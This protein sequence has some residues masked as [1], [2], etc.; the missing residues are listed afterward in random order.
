MAD[1]YQPFVMEL[2]R[3]MEACGQHEKEVPETILLAVG[4]VPNAAGRSWIELLTRIY[5]NKGRNVCNAKAD[6]EANLLKMI[7][8]KNKK[9]SASAAPEPAKVLRGASSSA[10]PSRVVVSPSAEPSRVV[11]LPT[12]NRGLQM[13]QNMQR[14][15]WQMSRQLQKTDKQLQKTDKRQEEMIRTLQDGVRIKRAEAVRAYREEHEFELREEA[16][17]AIREEL[18]TEMAR[19][20]ELKDELR[21]ELKA[22]MAGDYE[23]KYQLREELKEELADDSSEDL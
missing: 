4:V 8:E 18:K 5:M 12:K 11:A 2:R 20:Y 21:A 1:A 9:R 10:E 15:Q 19:D 6:L 23:L 7:S 3:Q 14:Q 17:D 16:I 13:L 22:E